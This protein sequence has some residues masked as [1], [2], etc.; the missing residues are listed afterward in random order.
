MTCTTSYSGNLLLTQSSVK[1]PASAERI[2]ASPFKA[3]REVGNVMP[4]S[5][6]L[7]EQMCYS[8]CVPLHVDNS[9]AFR[10][11]PGRRASGKNAS[12]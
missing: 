12:A 9:K 7:V 5:I 2:E 4:I 11:V 8:F 3:D 6:D 1:P 10:R